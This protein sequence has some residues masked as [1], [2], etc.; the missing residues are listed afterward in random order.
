MRTLRRSL[1]AALALAF[2]VPTAAA[3]QLT[4]TLRQG[5]AWVESSDLRLTRPGTHVTLRD[6]SWRDES[7]RSP[8]Y[9]G[10]GLTWW[11]PRHREWG[12]GLDLT[13]AKAILET[14]GLA[15]A[16][17]GARGRRVDE[18]VLVRDVVPALQFS[19]GLNFVTV[20]GYRR[21]WGAPRGGGA[22]G[23]GR[24]QGWP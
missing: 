10:V 23:V 20:N 18:S 7:F 9:Y 21:G 8:I 24:A 22:A 5:K 12:L 4:L 17:G 15:L 16:P 2:V 14:D 6:V 1:A 11:L 3:A 13:H 19:H